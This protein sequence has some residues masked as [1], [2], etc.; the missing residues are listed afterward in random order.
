MKLENGT[1]ST[2]IDYAGTK[3]EM[4]VG[5]NGE[6]QMTDLLNN[7]IAL[8]QKLD[9]LDVKLPSLKNYIT[10]SENFTKNPDNISKMLVQST[11]KE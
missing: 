1:R 4:K 2:S 5:E 3:L 11:E 7:D 8:Q 6:V 9:S 10:E